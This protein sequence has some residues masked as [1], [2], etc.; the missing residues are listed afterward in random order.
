M[1][2][3]EVLKMYDWCQLDYAQDKDGVTIGWD[4]LGAAKFCMMG[5]VRKANHDGVNDPIKFNDEWARVFC[6]L[7]T[8]TN[9]DPIGYNDTP[10]RTKEEVIAKLESIGE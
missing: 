8:V 6:M 4:S 2:P 3:S 5:C 7:E 1:K 9:K 10:G